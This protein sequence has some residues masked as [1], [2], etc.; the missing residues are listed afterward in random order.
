[1]QDI[2]SFF[3]YLAIMGGV[4]YMIRMIPFVLCKEK[5]KSRF[6]NSFLYYIPYAV[7]TAMTIP[8]IFY[9]TASVY[10]ALAGMVVACILS[11][12]EKHLLPVAA[13]AC[14]TVFVVELFLL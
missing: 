14:L 8:A 6:L 11:Y 3:I 5:I 1:M 2:T 9:S 13:G 7:L 4:T 10:S 12:F